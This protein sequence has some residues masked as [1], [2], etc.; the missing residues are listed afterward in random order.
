MLREDGFQEK[1]S[2]S[3]SLREL[4]A[5][6]PLRGGFPQKVRDVVT[7]ESWLHPLV[8]MRLCV[9]MCVR[10]CMHGVCSLSDGER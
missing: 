1:T 6:W 7:K 3:L 4:G 5:S 10:V 9:C 2:L 8:G